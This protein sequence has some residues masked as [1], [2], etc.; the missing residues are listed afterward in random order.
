LREGVAPSQIGLKEAKL[1]VEKLAHDKAISEIRSGDNPDAMTIVSGPKIIK[2][3]LD[4]G[5]GPMELDLEGMQIKALSEMHTIGLDA[6]ADMLEMVDVF[7]AISEGEKV[8]VV[9]AAEDS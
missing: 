4:Y 5:D 1:A 2:V 7:R 3:V 9:K 6:C 8:Q